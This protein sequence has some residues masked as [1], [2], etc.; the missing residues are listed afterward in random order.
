MDERKSVEQRIAEYLETNKITI[1][2]VSSDTTETLS[3]IQ[4][5]AQGPVEIGELTYNRTD[6]SLDPVDADEVIKRLEVPGFIT[7]VVRPMAILLRNVRGN[8]YAERF[9]PIHEVLD[10][11]ESQ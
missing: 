3:F 11:V 10:R 6:G 5:R 9:D 7:H 2:P 4:Y 8:F 1:V